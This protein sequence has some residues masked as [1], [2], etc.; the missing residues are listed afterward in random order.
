MNDN[1]EYGVYWQEPDIDLQLSSFPVVVVIDG[2]MFLEYTES[3]LVVV[4]P[5]PAP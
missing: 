2:N 3:D 5:P 1:L 4:S